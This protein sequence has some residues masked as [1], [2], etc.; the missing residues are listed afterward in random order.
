MGEIEFWE[1]LPIFAAKGGLELLHL[2]RAHELLA[3]GFE[4]GGRYWCV[5]EFED[6]L[7]DVILLIGCAEFADVGRTDD[8]GEGAVG[9]SVR[10]NRTLGLEIGGEFHGEAGFAK[11]FETPAG[12]IHGVEE[13]ALSE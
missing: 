8:A 11:K 13:V 9:G 2:G 6:A 5:E 1:L 10:K 4:G 12:R 3:E 7:L